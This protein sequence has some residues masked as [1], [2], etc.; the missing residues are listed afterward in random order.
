MTTWLDLKVIILS[1]ISQTVKEKYYII[2]PMWDVKR[3]QMNYNK[4]E[5]DSQMQKTNS[6]LLQAGVVTGTVEIGEEDK[7]L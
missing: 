6:C 7:V 5:I 3:K 2:S 4:T 1:E